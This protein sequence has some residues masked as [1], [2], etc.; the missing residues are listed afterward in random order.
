[1]ETPLGATLALR[2]FVSAMKGMRLAGTENLIPEK[3]DLDELQGVTLEISN[4]RHEDEF[5]DLLY[6]LAKLSELDPES[7]EHQVFKGIGWQEE[8]HS[9]LETMIAIAREEQTGLREKTD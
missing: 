5:G 8:H 6:V 3:L 2:I 9:L 1:M 7:D 4:S